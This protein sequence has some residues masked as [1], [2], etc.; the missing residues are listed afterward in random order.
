MNLPPINPY[1]NFVVWLTATIIRICHFSVK[2]NQFVNHKL[3]KIN[4]T[5]TTNI[6]QIRKSINYRQA[7]IS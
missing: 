5:P 3:I 2:L 1:S 4:V 7:H 6:Y